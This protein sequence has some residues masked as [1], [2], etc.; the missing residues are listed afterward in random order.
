[1]ERYTLATRYTDSLD[2]KEVYMQQH[3]N[4]EYV[5]YAHVEELETQLEQTKVVVASMQAVVGSVIEEHTDLKKQFDTRET[6]LLNNFAMAALTGI[7]SGI[8]SQG[9]T[10]SLHDLDTNALSNC[11]F[12]MA[13]AM[14]AESA[15]R[16]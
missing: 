13:Y 16:I 1:M 12:K 3:M 9:T 2:L 5:K 14:V 8:I 10:F 7:I 6:V 15:K 4:G 11:S